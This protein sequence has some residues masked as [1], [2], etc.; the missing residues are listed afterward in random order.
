MCALQRV[1]NPRSSAPGNTVAAPQM[2]YNSRRAQEEE[3]FE[4]TTSSC[5][6][7]RET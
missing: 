4:K 2:L 5:E 3:V 1:Q 6:H 7:M